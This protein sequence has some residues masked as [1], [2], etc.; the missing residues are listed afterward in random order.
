M[1][2]MTEQI[3][4]LRALWDEGH[5]VAE[6]GRRMGLSKNAVVGKA[7][8]LDLPARESPIRVA[9]SGARPRQ[10]KPKRAGKN[11]LPPMDSVPPAERTPG[12]RTP[13]PA[14]HKG[15]RPVQRPSRKPT[16][17]KPKR[18]KA[19]AQAPAPSA[20]AVAAPAKHLCCWPIGDPGTRDFRFCGAPAKPGKPYCQ[21]HCDLAYQKVRE[22]EQAA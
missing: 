7:H 6:I 22:R 11:T 20:P 2:W 10:Y 1:D 15:P 21:Q 18:I 13:Q 3:V 8:R 9:G 17:P 4:E 5:S 14:S 12:G 19:P 16:K